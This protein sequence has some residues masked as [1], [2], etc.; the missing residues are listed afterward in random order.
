MA[1]RTAGKEGGRVTNSRGLEGGRVGGAHSSFQFL[2]AYPSIDTHVC[3]IT[4]AS[5]D[6]FRCFQC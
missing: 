2:H 3:T 4:H 5:P 1:E 6:R